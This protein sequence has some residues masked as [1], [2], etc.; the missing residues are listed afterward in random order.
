MQRPNANRG[1]TNLEIFT[2]LIFEGNSNKVAEFLNANSQFNVDAVINKSS[3]DPG[4][5]DTSLHIAIREG[6]LDL[7]TT[8]LGF[9]AKLNKANKAG[10]TPIQLAKQLNKIEAIRRIA[11]QNNLKDNNPSAD[12]QLILQQNQLFSGNKRRQLSEENY[13]NDVQAGNIEGVKAYL[14]AGAAPQYVIDTE[15]NTALHIAERKGHKELVKLLLE[16]G[17]Y[18]YIANKNG[19]TVLTTALLHKNY[20]ILITILENHDAN[21]NGNFISLDESIAIHVKHCFRDDRTQ[22]GEVEIECF[23]AIK[24][25]DIF[26]LKNLLQNYADIIRNMTF[27]NNETPLHYAIGKKDVELITLL[28]PHAL[29]SRPNKEGL[30]PIQVAQKLDYVYI[31]NL[32]TATP[33]L[34][35][36]TPVDKLLLERSKQRTMLIDAPEIDQRFEARRNYINAINAGNNEKL[37]SALEY[38]SPNLCVDDELN[39]GL[40]IA[41]KQRNSAMLCTLLKSTGVKVNSKNIYGFTPVTLA[42]TTGN[43]EA[44]QIIKSNL[45]EAVIPTLDHEHLAMLGM[46]GDKSPLPNKVRLGDLTVEM[47]NPIDL[48]LLAFTERAFTVINSVLMNPNYLDLPIDRELNSIL[49]IACTDEGV[50]KIFLNNNFFRYSGKA[51]NRYGLTPLQLAVKNQQWQFV[52]HLIQHASRPEYAT[53][54]FLN[55]LYSIYADVVRANREDV[56]SILMPYINPNTRVDDD[57][58]TALYPLARKKNV[59]L[60]ILEN[61]ITSG[62]RLDL[63]NIYNLTPLEAALKANDLDAVVTLTTLSLKH[64]FGRLSG[65]LAIKIMRIAI[66]QDAAQLLKLFI[67]NRFSTNFTM[68]DNLPVID[69]V[70][71]NKKHKTFSMMNCEMTPENIAKI[72]KSEDWELYSISFEK[73]PVEVQADIRAKVISEFKNALNTGNLSLLKLLVKFDYVF[74]YFKTN[75]GCEKFKTLLKDEKN[76]EMFVLLVETNSPIIF[77]LI[78]QFGVLNEKVEELF[79]CPVG[80]VEITTPIIYPQGTTYEKG[81][82][83]EGARRNYNIY[84]CPLNSSKSALKEEQRILNHAFSALKAY[85]KLPFVKL[86]E[87]PKILLDPATDEFY[88]NPVVASDGLTYERDDIIQYLKSHGNVLPSG[89]KQHELCKL[90]GGFLCYPNRIMSSLI[91]NLNLQVVL[92]QNQSKSLL[93]SSA[94][95]QQSFFA[96]QP[97][98]QSIVTIPSCIKNEK[99]N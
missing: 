9:G 30:T 39:T 1:L 34:K 4:F 69:Y 92:K 51:K 11:S 66:I 63:V 86:N 59:N 7:I 98:T 85:Y 84:R 29:I 3:R 83:D 43:W 57:L 87:I 32:F 82:L 33:N 19:D 44:L 26:K 74:G 64:E 70:I 96:S 53:V 36:L 8:L 94:L 75:E 46:A 48:F 78:N 47:P 10:L 97:V 49:H 35:G 2:S 58:N 81:T 60:K 61:L 16:R 79:D 72:I 67:D 88:R 93:P 13:F 73:L 52:C 24:N 41:I 99:N 22:F 40:H 42:A 54:D 80:F 77:E 17:A 38:V 55:E 15:G 5:L 31:L 14:D 50:Q 65:E 12:D 68:E 62:A 25:G 56:V 76:H 27:A 91:E 23:E 28:L 21:K 18:V 45:N 90:E 89:K 95:I 71:A 37:Q 20:E 6:H